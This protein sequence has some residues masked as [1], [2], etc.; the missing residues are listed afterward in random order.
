ML[1]DGNGK[2]QAVR[3][4]IRLEFILA[5]AEI[6]SPVTFWVSLKNSEVAPGAMTVDTNQ[7]GYWFQD[8][9]TVKIHLARK[10]GSKGTTNQLLDDMLLIASGPE[11]HNGSGSVSSSV[12]FSFGTS[13][14]GGFFDEVLTGN[15]GLSNKKPAGSRTWLPRQGTDDTRQ[16]GD[17]DPLHVSR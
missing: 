15:T 9:M 14:S 6:D 2:K 3:Q 7:A 17:G 12:S 8:K 11:T 13:F 5:K 1:K 4:T 16:G 10:S